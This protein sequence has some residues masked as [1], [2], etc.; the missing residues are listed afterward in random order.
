MRAH[1]CVRVRAWHVTDFV[2][3]GL[4]GDGRAHRGRAGLRMC[5]YCASFGGISGG[6]NHDGG[7]TTGRTCT[8]EVLL[9]TGARATGRQAWRGCLGCIVHGVLG[10]QVMSVLVECGGVEML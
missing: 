4:D 5:I 2:A 3:G 6:D 9:V 10:R 8:S 1:A 7:W